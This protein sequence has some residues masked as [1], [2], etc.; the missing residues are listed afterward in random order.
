[1][2]EAILS[3]LSEVVQPTAIIMLLVG[4]IIGLLFGALPGLGGSIAMA[5]LIP[6]TIGDIHLTLGADREIRRLVKMHPI[7]SQ[8]VFD[9][10]REQHIPLLRDFVDDVSA[11]VDE[12]DIVI[13]VA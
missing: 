5:L 12:P 2:I 8:T 3:S 1:M 4:N 9:P 10:Q 13:A 7:L 11:I 6:I